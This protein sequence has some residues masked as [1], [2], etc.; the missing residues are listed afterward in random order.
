MIGIQY[1]LSKHTLVTAIEENL[2]EF[3]CYLGNSPQG[4]VHHGPI[5]SWVIT[6]IPMSKFN[7][8]LRTQFPPNLTPLDLEIIIKDTLTYFK[9]RGVPVAWETSSSTQ[10]ADLGK[11]LEAHGLIEVES[12]PGMAINLLELRKDLLTP[13]GLTIEKVSDIAALTEWVRTYTTVFGFQVA[14]DAFLQLETNLNFGSSS[15][16]HRFIGRLNG[17]PVATSA[18]FLG[19]NS[20]GI[21]R[22]ATAPEARGQG[23]GAAMTTAPLYEARNLG[24]RIGILR[25]SLI[26]YSLYRRLGFQ[27]YCR[28]IRYMCSS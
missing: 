17:K 27:E 9:K 19:N 20:V 8:I 16:Y 14:E 13:T 15:R 26:G 24:Y 5:I 1:E 7:C 28:L 2:Y 4:E 22:V 3:Y 11:Y 12:L 23:I 21:W 6:G 25:S 18:L 10:P